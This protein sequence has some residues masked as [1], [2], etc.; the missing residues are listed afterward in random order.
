MNGKE[1]YDT[2]LNSMTLEKQYSIIFT[3]FSMPIMDGIT[4]TRKMRK[5]LNEI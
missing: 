1:S 2:L 3:D 5:Y 4:S